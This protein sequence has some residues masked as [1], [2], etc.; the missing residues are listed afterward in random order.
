MNL[1]LFDIRRSP[2]ILSGRWITRKS[3][4][5]RLIEAFAGRSVG[6]PGW[7]ARDR[8][9]PGREAAVLTATVD[10]AHHCGSRPCPRKRILDGRPLPFLQELPSRRLDVAEE[11]SPIVIHR[12][13][14]ELVRTSVRRHGQ[15]TYQSLR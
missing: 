6:R 8:L 13:E 15:A 14:G 2:Q 10:Q 11:P 5:D 1:L 12:D 3:A 9:L 4:N 7:Q